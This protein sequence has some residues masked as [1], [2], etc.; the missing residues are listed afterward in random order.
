MIDI[1]TLFFTIVSRGKANAV[2]HKAQ[3]CGAKGGTIL[4]GEGTVQSKLL[5]KMGLTE[6]HKEIL[7][8]SASEEL[9]DKLHD[10]LNKTF[11]FYK[12]NK[13][14]AFTIPFKRWQ[15]KSSEKEDRST[16]ANNN[17]SYYC[18]VTVLDK[19]RS[20]NCI[21]SARAAGAKGGTLIHGR[22][23]GIPTDFYFPLVI[24]PQKDIVIILTTKEKVSAIRE[25]IY[26]DLELGK[27]GNGII[28]TLPISRVS[29]LFESRSEENRGGTS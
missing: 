7:M 20:R 3:E 22:G 13:G 1:D 8:V 27:A 11:M 21:K 4:L 28:F 15:S 16:S 29:G 12:S 18:I 10:T 5:E 24:E 23:A 9:S 14:I 25:R 26:S 19:G 17:A 2:L 6:I